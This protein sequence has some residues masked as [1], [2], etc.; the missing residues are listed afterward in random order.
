MPPATQPTSTRAPA[1]NLLIAQSEFMQG[2][3]KG[4]RSC[5][6]C[7]VQGRRAAITCSQSQSG[8]SENFLAGA[9]L[10]LQASRRRRLQM[11]RRRRH[12]QAPQRFL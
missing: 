4:C 6:P 11:T 2:F 8:Y 7:G 3:I 9:N 5:R 10:R 1:P 12:K